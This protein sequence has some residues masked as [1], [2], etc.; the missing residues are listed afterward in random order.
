MIKYDK[1]NK[2]INNNKLNIYKNCEYTNF[3]PKKSPWYG[4]N[5]YSFNERNKKKKE[6]KEIVK[7]SRIQQNQLCNFE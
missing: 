7:K 5:F 3:F 6:K 2:A 1:N 4:N